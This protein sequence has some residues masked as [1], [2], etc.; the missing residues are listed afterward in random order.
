[1]VL[2]LT[3]ISEN[4]R[5]KWLLLYTLSFF[6]FTFILL[7]YG[8]SGPTQ[9]MSGVL[10]LTL[11][12]IPL[13]SLLYGAISFSEATPFMELILVRNISRETIFL[14]KFLGLGI[15][16]SCS[17]LLGVSPAL[18]FLSDPDSNIEL[19]LLLLF[20]G[21]LL[22]FIFLMISFVIAVYIDR[23]EMLLGI[24]L[25]LWFYFYIL[26]DLIMLAMAVLFREYPFDIVVLLALLLNPI[27][28]ARVVFLI[29]LNISAVT[30]FSMALVQKNL[31]GAGGF[32]L[33]FLAMICWIVFLY[34]MGLRKFR[35]KAL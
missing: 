4:I 22:H 29:K 6:I 32:I 15:G 23:K 8:T 7:K 30:G 17:F 3:E 18:F 28:L 12:I 2:L 25:V 16:L 27:D 14:G 21:V 35:D 11:L 20:L 10:S 9:A 31:G 26:Y 13:F 5:S 33:T 34:W 19:L 1:M 24:S